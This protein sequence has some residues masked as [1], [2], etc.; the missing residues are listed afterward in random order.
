[1]GL[2]HVP[3]PG[4]LSVV[5][6]T[7]SAVFDSSAFDIATAVTRTDGGGLVAELDPGWDVGGG[8]LNGGYLLSVAARAAVLE[9]PHPHPVAVSASYLR[10]PA[11]GPVTLTVVPGPAGRTLAHSLVT[12][13]DA[14]RD[15]GDAGHR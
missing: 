5:P 4:T 13:S 14:E 7:D 10:A 2:V 3:E 9:S 6:Q 15:D 12:L 1:V 8:I 11:A